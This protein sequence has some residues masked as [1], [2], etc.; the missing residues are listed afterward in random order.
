VSASTGQ[1]LPRSIDEAAQ[2]LRAGALSVQALTRGFL[3]C[4]RKLQPTLNAYITIT[5]SQAL[6][7]AARLDSELAQEND[8]GPLH[9]IPVI[10]KDSLATRGVPTT[11]GSAYLRERVTEDDAGIVQRL[12]AAG[13]VM[14]G[15]ANMSEFASG[16][17]GVNVF[18]GNVHNPWDLKRAPGGSSSGTG[19]AVASG[20][21]LTGIGTD[22]G[23]SIRQPASRCGI[24]GLRPTFG[25]VS[26]AGVWPRTRTL[27]AGGPMTRCVKDAALMMNA[28]AGYDP[29]YSA[30]LRAPT[31]DFTRDLEL[32]VR[33]LKLGIIEGYTFNDID[34]EI[35]TVLRAAVEVLAG[36][37]A[38]IVPVRIP[39][40]SGSLDYSKLFSNVLLYEFNQ[41]LGE[42]YRNAPRELFG[43]AVHS[44]LA[45]GAQVSDE[46]YQNI[47][48]ERP[49]QAAAVKA[50][51][52]QVDA[53][54]APVLPNLT[55]LQTAGPEVW[56]RGRQFNLPFSFAGVPSV[57]LP[58][59]FARDM[60][61][62]LQIVGNDLQETL[63]LRISAAFEAAT[64]YHRRLPPVH[65]AGS[66]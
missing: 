65:C 1:L 49:G 30:S 63:L 27:G 18:F 23:G 34:A 4:S 52:Q 36:L 37:G 46:V 50:A 11:V 10:Y 42:K 19:A 20:M 66:V 32:G 51:F 16:S 55:P 45:R 61:V 25:R 53:L 9:G 15:K 29:A 13:M 2:Q 40:L 5:E 28:L 7:T 41:I 22:A 60:P 31:E 12:K 6:E 8:R 24:F 47:L 33:G 35:E 26:L 21:C 48:R 57:S 58:C 3:D 59:G 38:E 54:L 39:A 43:P 62:G 14:L 17:S 64:D 44:D 56:A